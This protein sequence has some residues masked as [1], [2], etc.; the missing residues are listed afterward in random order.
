MF[1]HIGGSGSV[2]QLA[3]AVGKVFARIKEPG[4]ALPHAD[5]DPAQTQLETEKL[6]TNPRAPW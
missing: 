2:E 1:M 3:A 4:T 5:I 6:A